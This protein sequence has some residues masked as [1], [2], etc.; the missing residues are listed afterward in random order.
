MR[1]TGRSTIQILIFCFALA[2]PSF[3]WADDS[4]DSAPVSAPISFLAQH[5]QFLTAD[6]ITHFRYV[7]NNPGKVTARDLY[8]KVSTRVQINL[9][10]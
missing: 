9:V 10:G 2:L 6:G 8:Y 7:D 5:L 4:S 1:L 3:A